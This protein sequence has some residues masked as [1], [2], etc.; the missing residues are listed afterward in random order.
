M[1]RSVCLVCFYMQLYERDYGVLLDHAIPC[2]YVLLKHKRQESKRDKCRL[3]TEQHCTKLSIQL[4]KSTNF[5]WA[6]MQAAK[7]SQYN[8]ESRGCCFHLRDKFT[9]TS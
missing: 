8:V 5:G 2:A 1:L 6:A 4:S 9:V 3:I 7:C